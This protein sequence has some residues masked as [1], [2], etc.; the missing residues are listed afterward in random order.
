MR[1]TRVMRKSFDGLAQL[2]REFLGADP[3]SG[4][5]SVF[6]NKRG[7]LLKLLYWDRDGYW[8]LAG[9]RVAIGRTTDS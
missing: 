4:N 7:D 2:V 9:L 6:R 5:L 8:I 3:L 1:A